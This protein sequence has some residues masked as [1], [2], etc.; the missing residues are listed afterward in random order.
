MITLE[1]VSLCKS[2]N[3]KEIKY[4]VK[5]ILT[6]IEENYEEMNK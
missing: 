5:T 3:I 4:K 1:S 2:L 6:T